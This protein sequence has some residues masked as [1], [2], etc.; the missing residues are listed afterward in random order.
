MR[1][2]HLLSSFVT[3]LPWAL[4]PDTLRTVA[5]VLA[6]H[7]AGVDPDETTIARATAIAEA[8]QRQTAAAQDMLPATLAL[9]PIQGIIVPRSNQITRAS[10]MTTTDAI[11]SAL[12]E[13]LSTTAVRA[14]ILDIDSP[15]GSVAGGAVVAQALR[16][17]RVRVPVVAQ[18]Q[19]TGASLAYWIAANATEVVAAPGSVLG[20]IGTYLIHDDLSSALDQL[21]IRRTYISAGEYKT[22][23]NEAT[24][25]SADAKARLQ[26]LVDQSY[27]Q[28]TRDVALGRGVPHAMVL[29][30]FGKGKIVTAEDALALGMINRIGT[31]RETI[32]RVGG[33][34]AAAP[35]VAPTPAVA[36]TPRLTLATS[37]RPWRQAAERQFRTLAYFT[38]TTH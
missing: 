29:D 33:A 5:D 9:I 22:D 10:G 6:R 17:A 19:Y 27:A 37:D 7:V 13:A 11:L 21:G 8:R 1:D 18:V 32:A 34:P 25:L 2:L 3:T 30:G 15:G 16:D 35:A 4:D 24:P 14:I 26:H 31:L 38:P 12:D 23:P 28:F 20:S 36:E